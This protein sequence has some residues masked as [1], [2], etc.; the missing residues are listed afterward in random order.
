[1]K[2]QILLLACAAIA[3]CMAWANDSEYYTSGN[4]LIPLKQ[5]TIRVTKEVLSID[6]RDDGTAFVDV[7]YEFTNPA[8]EAKTILMGFEADPPSSY[9]D[10]DEQNTNKYAHPYIKNF[11]VEINGQKIAY[12]NAISKV[13]DFRP[14]KKPMYLCAEAAENDDTMR[15]LAYVYYFNA[16]FKPGVNKVHHTYQYKLGMSTYHFYFLDYKLS[17]AARWANKQIDDFTLIVNAKKTAK[18]FFVGTSNLP[19]MKPEVVSG[20][21]KVRK[22]KHPW[23]EGVYEWEIALRNGSIRFHAKNFRPKEELHLHSGLLFGSLKAT[24]DRSICMAS[25]NENQGYSEDFL[26][27][28]IHNLPYANRGRVFKDAAL[29]KFFESCWW[30]M[31]DPN[32]KDD[33]S[34]FTK[35]DWEY[36]YYKPE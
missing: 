29:Q 10:D 28:V 21:G 16:T 24:Y 15:D 35:S 9:G 3:A 18:H 22:S 31:P 33:T 26:L 1:M 19:D 11:S 23:E 30:Y 8:K 14:V 27:R 12:K 17:P 6:L 25:Y 13:G 4:Q 34:D 2:K 36:I 32:Y 5:T 7:Q 20:K